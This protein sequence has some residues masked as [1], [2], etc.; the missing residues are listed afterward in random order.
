[1]SPYPPD[2]VDA[3][4]PMRIV[5]TTFPSEADAARAVAAVLA[6]RLAVCAQRLPIR[7][8]YWWK[9][10][11]ES[12]EEVLVLFKTAPKRVGAL[13]RALAKLHP[14]E[15]PELVELDVPRVAPGYLAYLLETLGEAPVAFPIDRT[16]RRSG[17]PRARG[18]L[19]P[20]GTRAPRRRR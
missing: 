14:Y 9:G 20:R 4:G 15:V 7:S 8:S 19:R 12:G 16:T 10:R 1:M 17:A 5:L 13:F 2:P 11:I 3:T 18:A 6:R